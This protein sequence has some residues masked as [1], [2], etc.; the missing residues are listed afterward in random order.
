MS[1]IRR[2]RVKYYTEYDR[3]DSTCLHGI[4]R[5]YCN[6]C[7]DA[8]ICPH[9]LRGKIGCKYCIDTFIDEPY[10]IILCVHGKYPKLC[11]LCNTMIYTGS[12]TVHNNTR[13]LELEISSLREQLAKLKKENE[14]MRE[15]VMLSPDGKLYFELMK[16][17]EDKAIKT[18]KK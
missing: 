17:F 12:G 2:S 10:Q 1:V 15:H 16:D 13:Q 14:D 7:R 8:A 9:G 6:I 4:Q 3:D 5:I 18:T 11:I